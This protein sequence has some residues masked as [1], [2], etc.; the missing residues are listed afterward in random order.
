MASRNEK[1]DARVQTIVSEIHDASTDTPLGHPGCRAS[2]RP[3]SVVHRPRP[4][5]PSAPPA[6][7][8]VSNDLVVNAIGPVAGKPAE[9]TGVRIWG[10]GFQSG[11]TV[12]F[13]G[14]ATPATVEVEDIIL[15]T[16]RLI[17]LARSTSSSST[18]TAERTAWRRRL[19][20]SSVG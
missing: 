18:R 7:P 13:D 11:A 12:T 9:H 15:T 20:T 6:P 10:N 1:P 16:R 4:A 17:Q 14:S 8:P 2:R 19:P 5:T 3:L